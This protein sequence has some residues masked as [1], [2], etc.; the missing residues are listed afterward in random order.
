MPVSEPDDGESLANIALGL[1]L[2]RLRTLHS[3]EHWQPDQTLGFALHPLQKRVQIDAVLRL[4][5]RQTTLDTRLDVAAPERRY[6][7]QLHVNT[8]QG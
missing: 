2:G 3:E 6:L 8:R 1:V 5:Q 7:P 4:G